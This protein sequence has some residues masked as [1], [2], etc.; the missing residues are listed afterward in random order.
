MNQ[1]RNPCSPVCLFFRAVGQHVRRAKWRH[2]RA[3]SAAVSQSRPLGVY[4][5]PSNKAY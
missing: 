1:Y 3:I 4:F 5:H 2:I